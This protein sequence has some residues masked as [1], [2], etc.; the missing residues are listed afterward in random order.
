MYSK[1]S[2][3]GSAAMLV[4]ITIGAQEASASAAEP[5]ALLSQQVAAAA[6]AQ[7]GMY[8]PSG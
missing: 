6:T 2:L 5:C 7:N 4:G 8:E 3:V 1:L